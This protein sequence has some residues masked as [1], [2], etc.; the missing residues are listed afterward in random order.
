MPDLAHRLP[1]YRHYRP[2]DL[3]VVR[4]EGRDVYLGKF[5]SSESHEK[6]RR[7]IAEWLATGPKSIPDQPGQAA[8]SAPTVNAIILAFLTQHADQHYRHADGTP[9]GEYDNFVLPH[10]KMLPRIAP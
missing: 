6:Y 9:T 7:V 10:R 8:E 3:A 5:G 1:K 4:I 2:K